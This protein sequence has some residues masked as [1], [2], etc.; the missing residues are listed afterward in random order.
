MEGCHLPWRTRESHGKWRVLLMRLQIPHEFRQT[1]VDFY[2]ILRSMKRF[3]L[4]NGPPLSLNVSPLQ[5]FIER[6]LERIPNGAGNH[7]RLQSIDTVWPNGCSESESKSGISSGCPMRKGRPEASPA[8]VI[9]QQ[10]VIHTPGPVG[11][12]ISCRGL[13]SEFRGTTVHTARSSPLIKN[14]CCF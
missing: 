5:V 6:N 11:R 12:V 7:S 3:L 14:I 9:E 4:R 13:A 2:G 10:R 8:V 1:A